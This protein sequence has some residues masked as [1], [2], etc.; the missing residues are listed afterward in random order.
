MVSKVVTE[1]VWDP[2]G[3]RLAVATKGG[4]VTVYVVRELPDEPF[5][6]L[7]I[8]GEIRDPG[9]ADGGTAHRPHLLR[10]CQQFPRGAL[11]S[12]CWTQREASEEGGRRDF[13][14]FYPLYFDRLQRFEI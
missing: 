14:S 3:E 6:D 8:I 5:V 7:G 12:V 1:M 9:S 11:L 10:F 4:T 2:S 13:V